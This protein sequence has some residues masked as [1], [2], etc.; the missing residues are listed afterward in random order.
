MKH[1]NDQTKKEI[2]DMWLAGAGKVNEIAKAMNMPKQSVYRA[3][4]Q[5]GRWP[6]FD[7]YRQALDPTQPTT[8]AGYIQRAPAKIHL[9]IQRNKEKRKQGINT[10]CPQHLRD[11]GLMLRKKGFPA[12]EIAAQIGV[13]ANAI[14]LWE[15]RMPKRKI[16]DNPKPRGKVVELSG[17]AQVQL[18]LV[19]RL[20]VKHEPA[21][22][23]VVTQPRESWIKRVLRKLF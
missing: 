21:S 1:L 14:Y 5:S 20:E 13:S 3:L 4:A 8:V 16:K 2:V 22:E 15:H 12:P 6:G 17:N 7:D 23:P 10:Q 19:T 18:P 11:F 9:A